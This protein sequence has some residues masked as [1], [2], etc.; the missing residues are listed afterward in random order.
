MKL[1]AYV[2]VSTRE[3]VEHGQGLGI[4]E[5][6]IRRWAR[7][8]GH[9]IVAVHRD[10]GVSGAKPATDRPGLTAALRDLHNGAAGGLIVRDLDRLAREVSVQEAVLAEVWTRL[11]GRVFTAVADEVLKDDP[12]D[13]M[14]TAMRKMAGVFHELDRLLIVKRLRDGRAAK[15]AT[16]GHANGRY[17]YGYG[18][19][20][21][22]KAQQAALRR[23]RAMQAEGLSTRAIAQTLADEGHPTARGGGWS[24][25]VVARI[26]AREPVTS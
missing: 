11:D 4:Q 26:L 13:P 16:G 7:A 6:A 20:G 2:R 24:P 23:M 21:P 10:E 5:K 19:N 15:A 3:Q 25:P 12:D 17:C 9:K 1:V 22:I 18:P 14:R 8:N